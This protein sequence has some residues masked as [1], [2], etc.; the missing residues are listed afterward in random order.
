MAFEMRERPKTLEILCQIEWQN[1]GKSLKCQMIGNLP[2]SCQLKW[3]ESV[4]KIAVRQA[5]VMFF[6]GN[7]HFAT[8]R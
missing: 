1:N 6:S 3:Q 8:I 2:H 4:A 7:C 5:S